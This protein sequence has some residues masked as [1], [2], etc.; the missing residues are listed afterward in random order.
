MGMPVSD[1]EDLLAGIRS[2]PDDDA[3]R[4]ILAD[5]LEENGQEERAEFVRIQVRL[6]QWVADLKERETLQSRETALFSQHGPTWLAPLR[7][8][9]G[10]FFRMIRGTVHA[11]HDANVVLRPH[12]WITAVR[13]W[14][15]RTGQTPV[16]LPQHEFLRE[17]ATR[18]CN[19]L[20][21]WFQRIPAGIF[22]MGTLP[23]ES[24]RSDDELQRI[25]T[26]TKPYALG[27][28]PVTVREYRELVPELVNGENAENSLPNAPA[29]RIS[30]EEAT[31]Y[32]EML[33]ALPAEQ[34]AG[35][36]YR[37]PTEAE[38][39]HACRAGSTTIYNMTNE[40][41]KIWMNANRD[42]GHALP[43]GCFDANAFGL[44][45]QHGQVREWCSDWYVVNLARYR[46]VDPQG[47]KRAGQRGRVKVMR[48]G[49]W[50]TTSPTYC[51]SGYRVYTDAQDHLR[52]VGFRVLCEETT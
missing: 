38:W 2:R 8:R 24:H 23:T 28:F 45:D 12:P 21:M 39:E 48:G 46:R 16:L 18:F 29:E 35:R 52:G 33:S 4:L 36:R 32:C 49:S 5:W 7:Q 13:R 40:Y 10:I 20:G 15:E 9:K 50:D 11:V 43:V 27:T 3:P 1:F 22:R 25:I 17:S 51:R 41:H 37:L 6:G 14:E 26:L 19:S 47:P 44:Y 42:Y 34:I 31:A 30:W